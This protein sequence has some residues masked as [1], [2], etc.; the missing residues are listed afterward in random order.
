MVWHGPAVHGSFAR[1]SAGLP[2]FAEAADRLLAAMVRTGAQ[3]EIQ[4]AAKVVA[5]TE[6]PAPAPRISRR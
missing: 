4:S 3:V 1:W 6:R 2:Q 5:M